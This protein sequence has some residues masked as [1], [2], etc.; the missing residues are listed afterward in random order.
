MTE[1]EKAFFEAIDEHGKFKFWECPK[2]CR[3]F[4]DWDGD[5]ATC[6]KCGKENTMDRESIMKQW[7]SWRNYIA[8]GGE[9]SWPRDEFETLL[10]NLTKPQHESCIRN[11]REYVNFG[12]ELIQEMGAEGWELVAV[13]PGNHIMWFKR[14]K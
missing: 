1:E 3:N 8:E 2:M 12:Y 11:Y 14:E 9:G 6:R 13:D 4:V 5:K 7:D 10:D